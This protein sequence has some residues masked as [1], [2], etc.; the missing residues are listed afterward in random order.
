MAT[1]QHKEV[2]A[3]YYDTIKEK[4][5]HLT[6][7]DIEAICRTPAIFIKDTIRSGEL[8]DINIKYVG[9]MCVGETRLVKYINKL[10]SLF[11]A[12]V[13]KEAEYNNYITIAKKKLNSI[14]LNKKADNEE[15]EIIGSE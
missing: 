14:R 8:Q 15:L 9:K 5:P 13:L 11:N 7:E 12:G 4:Y 6:L 10:D 2:I 3:L 1:L